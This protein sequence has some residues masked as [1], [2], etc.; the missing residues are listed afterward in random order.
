[1]AGLRAC[2]GSPI[3]LCGRVRIDAIGTLASEAADTN[4]EFAPFSNN[5]RTR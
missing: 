1:M 4:D 5:R 2:S 3:R